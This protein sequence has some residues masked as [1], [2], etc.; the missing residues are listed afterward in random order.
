MQPL[1]HGKV[2]G[3]L[4]PYPPEAAVLKKELDY[5]ALSGTRLAGNRFRKAPGQRTKPSPIPAERFSGPFGDCVDRYFA[6]QKRPR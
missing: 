5:I 6:S 1:R 4:R 3:V 2:I